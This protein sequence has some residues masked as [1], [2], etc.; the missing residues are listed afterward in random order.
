MKKLVK[1]STVW[2]IFFSILFFLISFFLDTTSIWYFLTILLSYFIASF[3]LYVSSWKKLLQGRVLDENTLMIIA[4]IG[5]FFIR[6]YSEAIVVVVLYRIGELLSDLAVTKSRESVLKLMDLKCDTVRLLLE[7]EEVLVNAEDAKINDLFLVKPGE[8]IPLDG[9]VVKGEAFLDTSSLTGESVPKRVGVGDNVL[10]GAICQDKVLTV[11]A[12]SLAEDSTANRILNLVEKS[13]EKKAD[14][15]KWITR[16]AK[17]YTPIVVLLAAVILL[18]FWY[19]QKDFYQAIYTACVFLVM[20]CPCALVISVPLSYFLAIG[21]ASRDGILIKGGKE[22]EQLRTIKTAIF[23]KTG[24][25]TEGVF[26]VQKIVSPTMSQEK[27]L[28]IAAYGEYYSNHPISQSVLKKYGKKIDPEKILDFEQISGK[29]IRFRMDHK[30]YFLGNATLFE[31]KGILLDVPP[32]I[33]TTIYVA[34]NRVYIGH[35]VIADK[36]KES[37][38]SIVESL[39]AVGVDNVVMLSGDDERVVE[40]VAKQ[41]HIPSY[42]GKLLPEEKVEKVKH[43]KKEGCAGFVGDGINDVPVIQVADI[44]IAM[45]GIGSD[46]TIEASDVVFMKDD[47]SKLSTA[48]LLSQYTHRLVLINIWFAIGAKVLVL[49]LSLLG[50]GTIWLAV[51]ADVGVTL[52][53]VLHTLSILKRK[54]FCK[55]YPLSR[56][57]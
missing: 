13:T 8:K 57:K 34:E 7:E 41:L 20:S 38:Y 53:C 9:V 35:L 54:S 18:L 11:R 42:Y 6:E 16:F 44:G 47:V 55:M 52:L 25:I 24:T 49:F 33:G 37:S 51:L 43:W 48:I 32:E 39:A 31:E 14:T 40:S 21:R 17:I 36:I 56:T 22:L 10:S 30:T 46:A 27:L 12:T 5:A 1:N 19:F 50:L 29:G 3:D 15:E 23:D 4:T 45:G 28:E 2:K 26:A